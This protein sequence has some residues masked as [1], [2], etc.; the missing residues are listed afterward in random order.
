M[1][2]DNF[3]ADLKS[4][5]SKN[6]KIR[7]NLAEL[8]DDV[9]KNNESHKTKKVAGTSSLA[10]GATLVVAGIFSPPAAIAGAIVSTGAS[11][12][13]AVTDKGYRDKYN[14][15]VKK[16]QEINQQKID[17]FESLKRGID[18]WLDIPVHNWFPLLSIQVG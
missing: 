4:F 13:N 1:S 11:V 12:A 5:T 10:I 15:T 14:E 6:I 18:S 16:I 7:V 2:S 9:E 3:V 17:G 8:K